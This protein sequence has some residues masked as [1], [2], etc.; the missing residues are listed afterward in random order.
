MIQCRIGL[1]LQRCTDGRGWEIL[2]TDSSFHPWNCNVGTILSSQI[3]SLYNLYLV[4]V[5]LILLTNL[6]INMQIAYA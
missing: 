5:P 4:A 6:L 1:Q 3:L 2:K